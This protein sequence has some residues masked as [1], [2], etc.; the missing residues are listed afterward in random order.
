MYHTKDKD[1]FKIYQ[2]KNVILMNRSEN[3]TSRI[4]LESIEIEL[5]FEVYFIRW[6]EIDNCKNLNDINKI[7]T[8]I[9]KD[10]TNQNESMVNNCMANH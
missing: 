2:D 9:K 8:K 4:S 6:N 5:L 1:E 3:I 10:V 7:E